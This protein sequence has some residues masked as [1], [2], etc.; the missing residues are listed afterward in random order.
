MRSVTTAR[1]RKLFAGL[2]KQIQRRAERAYLVWRNDP[3]YPS[4]DFSRVHPSLPI[5][6]ADIGKNWRA[7]A[8][9]E[10]DT[11]KW[12]WIGSHSD[13]DKLLDSL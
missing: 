7:V 12:F 1:F 11:V 4:L 5:Y 3:H 2:P 10:N 13:Y 9:V 8:I 6:S